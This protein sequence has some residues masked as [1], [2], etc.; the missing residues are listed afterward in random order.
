MTRHVKET[1]PPQTYSEWTAALEVLK[2]RESD[3]EILEV[4]KHGKLE[5]QS[6]VADRFFKRF[7]DVVNARIDFASLR[8][9]REMNHAGGN[10]GRIVGAL[11]SLRREMSFLT[12]VVKITAIPEETREQYCGLLREQAD[13]MQQSLEDSAKQDRTG[14]LASIVRN[15]KVNVFD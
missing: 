15:N 4:M 1:S 10:E 2:S 3:G 13:K 8:F 7:S 11:L 12:Q 5:W 14:K 6:G 9:Q